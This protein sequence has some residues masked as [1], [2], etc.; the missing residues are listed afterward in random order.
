MS[1]RAA[2]QRPRWMGL[3]PAAVC[4]AFDGVS[5]TI[6]GRGLFRVVHG[7]VETYYCPAKKRPFFAS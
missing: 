1:V 6:G 4:K 5:A 2:H 7:V 3:D